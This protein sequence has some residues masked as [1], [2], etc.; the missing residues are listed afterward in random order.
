MT[1]VGGVIAPHPPIIVPGVGGSRLKD[2]E[3]TL[4][5][6]HRVSVEAAEKRPNTIVLLSPHAPI[7][8]GEMGV[9]LAE[10]YQG[11]LAQF[12]GPE[13]V[14]Q[15]DHGSLV[16]LYFLLEAMSPPPGLVLLSV[17]LLGP[18]AHMNFGRAVAAAVDL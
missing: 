7:S 10:R 4:T 17:S 16:P 8:P 9:S 1:L 18:E 3:S 11:S 15:L 14:V 5:A 2:V 12:G 13:V 6:M